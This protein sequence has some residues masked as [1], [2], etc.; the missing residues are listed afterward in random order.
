MKDHSQYGESTIISNIFNK[1]GN[2]NKFCVE[3]GASDG[4]WLSNVRMFIEDGWDFI[5]MDYN[6]KGNK[7]VKEEFITAENIN[8]LFKKYSV[9]KKFDLL[10]IDMDGNDYWI[11]EKIEYDPSVVVIEYNSNF[12]HEDSVSLEYNPNHTFDGTYAYSASLK[13][14]KNLGERKG[15][16]LNNEVAFTNLIFV[17]KEFKNLLSELNSDIINLPFHHHEQKLKNKKFIKV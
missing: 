11:W 1:I 4:Y 7:E 10:S 3:F 8:D 13:A 15:Y 2:I 5:Q 12:S 17:K 9:P 6:N 16:F 14:L